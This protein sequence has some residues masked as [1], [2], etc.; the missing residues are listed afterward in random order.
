MTVLYSFDNVLCVTL[1]AKCLF[2]GCFNVAIEDGE[3]IFVVLLFFSIS[4][5]KMEIA[6]A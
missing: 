6:F 1:S 4:F 5:D 3:K 2:A